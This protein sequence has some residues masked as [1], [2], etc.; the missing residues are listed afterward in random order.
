MKQIQ[1]LK[2]HTLNSHTAPHELDY[3]PM[4]VK[5]YIHCGYFT[6][7]AVLIG[8]SVEDTNFC[9]GAFSFSCTRGML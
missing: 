9:V 4:C 2:S 8:F 3:G 6:E 1:V 5:K 7:E